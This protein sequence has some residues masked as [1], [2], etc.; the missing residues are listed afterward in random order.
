MTY[1]FLDYYVYIEIV[2]FLAVFTEAMLGVP[3]F[4]QNYHNH[5]T[6]GMRQVEFFQFLRTWLKCQ[7]TGN[8][9]FGMLKL[10]M[11]VRLFSRAGNTTGQ[12]S[13]CCRCER[14]NRTCSISCVAMQM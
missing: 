2:G 4:Y 5:S 14:G 8:K 9:E 6:S 10:V 13:L 11:H 12:I 7:L 3:Q 1:L